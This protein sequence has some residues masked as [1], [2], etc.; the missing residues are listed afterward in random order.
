MTQAERPLSE[1]LDRLAAATPAPGGGCA[2]AWCCALGAGLVEMAA[3]LTVANRCYA[4]VHPRMREIQTRAVALRAEALAAG[5]R[6]AE[7]Y[8]AVLEAR[9]AGGAG[10]ARG[11]G[12]PRPERLAAALAAAAEPPLAVAAAGAEAGELGAEVAQRGNVELRGDAMAGV[13]L[14]EAATRAAARLVEL[15]LENAGD[16]ERREQAAALARRAW[17]A[18][19]EALA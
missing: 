8:A 10:A 15:N 16:D 4:E 18:R 1:L 19:T 13:L 11:G 3:G 12:D 14:A 2:A 7:V 5:D 17:K 6:D 9:R